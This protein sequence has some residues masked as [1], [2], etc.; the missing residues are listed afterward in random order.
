MVVKGVGGIPEPAPDRSAKVRDR[1]RDDVKTSVSKEDGVQISEKAQ[2]AA[3]TARL[4]QLASADSGVRADK[5]AAA[6]ERMEQGDF[7]LPEVVAEV[8]KRLD[9]Y[10][11]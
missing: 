9:K 7:R 2:E 6:K 4:V 8:A 10:L 11:P 5:V 3:S 1:A